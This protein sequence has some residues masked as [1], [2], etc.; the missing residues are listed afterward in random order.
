MSCSFAANCCT[1][2][3]FF[4]FLLDYTCEMHRSTIIAALV[5]TLLCVLTDTR[6]LQYQ[7]QRSLSDARLESIKR[8]LAFVD[9]DEDEY[10]R[11]LERLFTACSCVQVATQPGGGSTCLPGGCPAGCGNSYDPTTGL[12]SGGSGSAKAA[13]KKTRQFMS[14]EDH[15]DE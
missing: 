11:L 3:A 4:S 6:W 8:L 7:Q 2:A 10:L 12:C 13:G 1:N 9:N 15:F 14:F 5:L